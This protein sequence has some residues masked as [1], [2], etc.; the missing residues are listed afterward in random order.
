MTP[1]GRLSFDRRTVLKAA[2][3]GAA[4]GV[5]VGTTAGEH[6]DQF[7]TVRTQV[8]DP[9]LTDPQA[10]TDDGFVIGGPYVPSMGWHFLNQE[11]VNQA[12]VSG[13]DVTRP[14]V[15]VYVD[16]RFTP[17]S[18]NQLTFDS[19][20]G[21]RLGA[22]EYALPRGARG[23]TEENPP[24]VFDDEHGDLE[25]SEEN[26][27]HVHPKAEHAFLTPDGE[28][29]DRSEEPKSYWTERLDTTNWLEIVPGGTPGNTQL[30]AGDQL[31]GHFG[32]ASPFENR[33]VVSSSV[34]PD[35]LTLHV[36]LGIDNPDGVFAGHNSALEGCSKHEH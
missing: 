22:V 13:I 19:E 21:L 26:G 6:S 9:Y 2:G 11:N 24:D 25:T 33:T 20:T 18:T 14:Q 17:E 27:W 23:H 10:A 3:A 7:E 32:R 12:A 8:V 31:K 36:W 15:L 1:S 30:S 34:H 28:A 5:G 29:T 16:E 4:L 35:L